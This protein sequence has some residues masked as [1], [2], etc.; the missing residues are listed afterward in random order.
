M[1]R[2]I[3]GTG[4]CGSTLLSRMV[5]LHPEALSLHEFFT[6]LN[7]ERRFQGGPVPAAELVEILSADRR[8]LRTAAGEEIRRHPA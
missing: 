2:F 8:C 5:G 1:E 7:R 3:V 6:G 4:R